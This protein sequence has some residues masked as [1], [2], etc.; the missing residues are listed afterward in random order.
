MV[1]F[2]LQP[3][4]K[5]LGNWTINYIPPTNGKYLGQL[6]ITDKRVIFISQ[7]DISGI[8]KGLTGLAGAAAA[9]SALGLNQAHVTY[10]ENLINISIPRKDIKEVKSTSSFLSKKV[11]LVLKDGS[12]HTFDYGMLSVKKVLEVLK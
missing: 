6:C 11:I 4:E 1:D 2:S 9:A 5:K 10:R 12:E 8:T 3:D 7:F